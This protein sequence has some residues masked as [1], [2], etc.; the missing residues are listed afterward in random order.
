M[1]QEKHDTEGGAHLRLRAQL[2]DA[3]C[4]VIRRRG[5]RQREAAV[6][7]GV[8]Q[9]RVSDLVRG[10]LT[11][12]SIDMLVD[13]LVAADVGVELRVHGPGDAGDAARWRRPRR[14]DR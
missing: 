14:K 4:A 13:M 3:V 5:L 1:P 10:K 8:A 2:M 9:P 7:F 11:L 12:F 6:L